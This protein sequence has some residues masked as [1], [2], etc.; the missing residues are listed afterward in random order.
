MT[1]LLFVCWAL[2][3]EV[4]VF[5]WRKAS[6][7]QPPSIPI[8]HSAATPIAHSAATPVVHSTATETPVELSAPISIAGDLS[9]LN[10]S[11]SAWSASPESKPESK[12]TNS[13]SN[14]ILR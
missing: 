9:S 8:A 1:L 4:F 12:K 11:L 3:V 10:Q 2:V 7:I 6:S 13:A 5:R 14:S